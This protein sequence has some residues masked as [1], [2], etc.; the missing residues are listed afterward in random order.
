M[1]P[2]EKGQPYEASCE[3][4]ADTRD[5]TRPRP[6][7]RSRIISLLFVSIVVT[8]LFFRAPHHCLHALSA[9]FTPKPLTI[10]Q[11]VKNI[12]STTPLIGKF[13]F[14][15]VIVLFTPEMAL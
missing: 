4:L 15:R 11:R 3:G 5:E 6:S 10:E 12:L 14:P 2:H 9:H 1:Y 13:L 8:S 7:T